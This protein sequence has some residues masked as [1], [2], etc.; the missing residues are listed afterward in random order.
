MLS[1]P[2]IQALHQLNLYAMAEALVEQSTLPQM[3]EL[4]FEDR[5]ALL[6]VR[7]L[8]ARDDRRLKRLLKL[9]KLKLNAA[10]ED[11]DYRSSRGLD[12]GKMAALI[13][14][15]WIR[16]GQ[17]L[18]VT[19]ATGTGKTWIACALGH[20]ACRQGLGVRYLRLPR[21]LE[22]LQIRHGDGSFGRYLNAIAK[23]DLL[24]LDDW[25]LAPMSGENARDLLDIID[26]RV[27]QRATLITSQLPVSHW[28]EILGEP[29]VADAVLDRLLQSAHR[30]EL[31]GDSLRRQQEPSHAARVAEAS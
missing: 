4:P 20:Q 24:I 13:P 10:I 26:D 25:G 7:E 1:Q 5:L 2:T 14:C 3:Q 29:T 31:K 19:G 9:A 28:H 27:G 21:F 11:L 18:L 23:V 16:Q 22:D 8:C 30:L 15:S 6:L 17:N 12:R